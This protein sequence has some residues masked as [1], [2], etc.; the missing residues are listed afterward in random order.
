MKT[1]P[2]AHFALI[3]GHLPSLTAPP[4]WLRGVELHHWTRLAA[5][6]ARR[7]CL[8]REDAPLLLAGA[9]ACGVVLRRLGKRDRRHGVESA[10]AS[11]LAELAATQLSR[12]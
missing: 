8:R 10:L 3:P 9:V 7:R 11:E 1:P 6:V 2:E 12:M 5:E 4:P